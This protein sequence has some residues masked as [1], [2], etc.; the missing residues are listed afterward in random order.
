MNGEHHKDW[1]SKGKAMEG[2]LTPKAL[3]Y[4]IPNFGVSGVWVGGGSGGPLC[5]P[6]IES[7]LFSFTPSLNG[8]YGIDVHLSRPTLKAQT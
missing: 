1:E 6:G 4:Q 8:A 2:L 7:P 3:P 5:L